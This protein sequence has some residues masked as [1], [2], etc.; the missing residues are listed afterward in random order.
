MKP[1]LVVLNG[2]GNGNVRVADDGKAKVE[3]IHG[4]TLNS[5]RGF[6]EGEEWEEGEEGEEWEEG[7]CDRLVYDV[8]LEN[9]EDCRV[10]SGV[11]ALSEIIKQ[12]KQQN[13]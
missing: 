11:V 13:C 6:G 3:G 2:L 1:L 10:N 7:K 12:K 5:A 4:R 9:G 8:L